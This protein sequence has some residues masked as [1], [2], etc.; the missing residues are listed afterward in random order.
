MLDK[1]RTQSKNKLNKQGTYHN[2]RHTQKESKKLET[3]RNT[4][5]NRVE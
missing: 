5:K 3:A 2:N 1:I 4:L